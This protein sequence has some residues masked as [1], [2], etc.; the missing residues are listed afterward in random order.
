M[1][2]CR[3][4]FRLS[5]FG[6]GTDYPSWFHENGGKVI[7]STINKYCYISC[8]QIPPFFDYKHRISYSKIESVKKNSDIE[9]PAVRAAFETLNIRTGLEIHYDG[10]LPA[11][12]GLGSYSAFTVSL[13]HALCTFHRHSISKMDLAKLAIYLEQDVMKECVGCQDQVATAFGGLN[14]I[15]FHRSGE[16]FVE[17]LVLPK[18]RL[19]EFENHLMLFYTGY[20]RYAPSIAKSKLENMRFKQAELQKIQALVE[21]AL[22]ILRSPNTSIEEL[23]R[24]LDES[25]HLK[26]SLSSKVSRVEI[27][28]IYQKA[29]SAGAIGGKII[30]A[31]GG[32]FL[33][34]FVPPERQSGVK[35][36]LKNLVNVTFS[37]ENMGS[38]IVFY[39]P[40][41]DIE[42]QWDKPEVTEKTMENWFAMS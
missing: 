17:P 10:D 14:I 12:A 29:L 18:T 35:E 36:E 22:D 1:I 40:D 3:T 34:L 37:L 23:G 24:L 9:H 5:F 32:G 39:D 13:L 30:G 31:G 19:E 7:V 2:I 20:S 6:G 28:E 4:P 16:I 21:E 8:R 42:P 27:D 33:L 15:E 25:W 41:P 26:R 38:R 11:R